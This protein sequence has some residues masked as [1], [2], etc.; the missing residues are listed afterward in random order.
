MEH[1]CSGPRLPIINIQANAVAF[2]TPHFFGCFKPLLFAP[3]NRQ[4]FQKE[5]S[6]AEYSRYIHNFCTELLWK[7]PSESICFPLAHCCPYFGTV[8]R[9]ELER[10]SCPFS[11]SLLLLL[12]PFTRT[13]KEEAFSFSHSHLCTILFFPRE[14]CNVQRGTKGRNI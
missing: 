6:R 9:L 5:Q 2:L 13:S 10:T 14:F 11:F 8:F 1:L 12:L 7:A 4:P 3:Q